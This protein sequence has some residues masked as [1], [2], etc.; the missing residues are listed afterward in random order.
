MNRIVS[1]TVTDDVHA[2][3]LAEI[4][5]KRSL[6][7]VLRDTIAVGLDT[8]I[9]TPLPDPWTDDVLRYANRAKRRGEGFTTGDMLRSLDI[10]S[11]RWS[12][13]YEMRIGAI[14]RAA[15]WVKRR[16]LRNGR[17]TNRWYSSQWAHL[18]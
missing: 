5:P 6:S 15:G 16:Q 17:R 1:T 10:V 18:G 7:A 13:K 12:R 4:T 3:L 8:G 11:H 2:R 14:L 9:D